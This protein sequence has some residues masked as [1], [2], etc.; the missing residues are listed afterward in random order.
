MAEPRSACVQ[1]GWPTS[2][3]LAFLLVHLLCNDSNTWLRIAIAADVPRPWVLCPR[4]R[5][6]H[7]AGR[8]HR[9]VWVRCTA[10]AT[11]RWEQT[12]PC[13][14]EHNT[15]CEEHIPCIRCTQR[16]PAFNACKLSC[17]VLICCDGVNLC[18]SFIKSMIPSMHSLL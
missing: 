1:R 14:S 2:S 18:V 16:L 4:G 12:I 10:R 3:T 6:Q 17:C 11:R 7:R 13:G 15:H 8:I 5:M 9:T